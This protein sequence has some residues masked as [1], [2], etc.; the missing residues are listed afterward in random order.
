[1]NNSE[2][3]G[4]TEQEAFDKANREGRKIRIEH[5]DRMYDCQFVPT[6]L[7]LLL[8]REG[9]VARFLMG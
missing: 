8:D 9:K 3:I 1:M 5:P 7:R 2:Y 6:R 4:L